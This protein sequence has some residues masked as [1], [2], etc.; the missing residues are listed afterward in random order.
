[1]SEYRVS[2]DTIIKNIAIALTG[3]GVLFI[4]AKLL[5]SQATQGR[6]LFFFQKDKTTCEEKTS[7]IEQSMN[8]VERFQ[9]YYGMLSLANPASLK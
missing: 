6:A 1:M 9:T 7:S 3:V 8:N 2:W 5:Y 4:A